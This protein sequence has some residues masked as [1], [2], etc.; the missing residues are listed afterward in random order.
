MAVVAT[1]MNAN[2][3]IIR[4][5]PCP[6]GILP[7]AVAILPPLFRPRRDGGWGF[8]WDSRKSESVDEIVF[9]DVAFV[10]T[11]HKT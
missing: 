9:G 3:L 11:R 4:V 5:V 7:R 10:W 6:I 2:K 8:R 1:P